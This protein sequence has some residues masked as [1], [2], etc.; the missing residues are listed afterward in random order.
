MM[1]KA[2]GIILRVVDYGETNKIITIYTKEFGKLGLMARGAKKPKSR[3]ASAT[4]HL[5]YGQFLFSK[6]K[7][8]GTLYQAETLDPLRQIK[9]DIF[10]LAHASYLV[11]IVDKLTEEQRPYPSL[12]HLL[13]KTLLAIE[14][15]LNEEVL[16]AIFNVKMLSIAGIDATMDRCIHCG[17]TIGPFSFSISG[18]GYLCHDCQMVDEYAIPMTPATSRLL[19]LF[20]KITIDQVGS[21]NLKQT[22]IDQINLILNTYFDQ[23]SG[24]N[25]KSKKFLDQMHHLK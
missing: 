7:N 21:I 16:T 2:E 10:K 19:H 18:G 12:Y 11:E 3:L 17:N 9:N 22:T 25:L 14:K 24:L 15:G 6:G 23:N 13:I 20:K 5:F 8:L 1:E 4:Q